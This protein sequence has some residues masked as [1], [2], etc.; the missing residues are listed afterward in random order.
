MRKGWGLFIAVLVVL[1]CAS[2]AASRLLAQVSPKWSGVSYYG[3][4]DGYVSCGEPGLAM[5][6]DYLRVTPD[7]RRKL[8]EID[9]RFLKTRPVLRERV[10][11]AR[12]RFI[13][14]IRDPNCTEDEIVSALRKLIQAREEMAVNTVSYILELRKHLTPNQ[15]ERLIG[16]VERGMCGL[17]GG[18]GCG[19]RG[20][21]ACGLG[22]LGG[23]NS[24]E[25]SGM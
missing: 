24:R 21:G 3:H 25:A 14:A 10:W 18:T 20:G 15:Q 12:D 16:L 13:A 6:Q 9:R 19:R 2:Y 4:P 1:G 11:E 22:I 23:R 17:T 7:Q 8:S 5:L